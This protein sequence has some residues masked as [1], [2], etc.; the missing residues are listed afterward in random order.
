MLISTY[1]RLTVRPRTLRLSAP[2]RAARE[3]L[4]SARVI[5]GSYHTYTYHLCC[6][7]TVSGSV[8]YRRVLSVSWTCSQ[9]DRWGRNSPPRDTEHN[10]QYRLR[11]GVVC[12]LGLVIVSVLYS[13]VLQLI[14]TPTRAEAKPNS[15]LLTL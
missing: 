1:R 2:L 10:T 7:D 6:A 5:L 3:Y 12:C 14:L 9:R 13:H 4:V 15:Y 8:F 11:E